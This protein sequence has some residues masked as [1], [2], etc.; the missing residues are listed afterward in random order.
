[1]VRS[2][3]NEGL[4]KHKQCRGKRHL[5]GSV[6]EVSKGGSVP[7]LKVIN[8]ADVPVLLLDGEEL[9]G[10]KQNRVLNTSILV[11]EKS[12]TI[13]P[14]SCTEQGRW[15]YTSRNFE[16][17]A[18]VMPSKMRRNKAMAV[19]G[20]LERDQ[21]FRSDQGE[22]W[23][24]VDTIACA[25]HVPCPTGAMSDVFKA[26]SND[27]DSYGDTFKRTGKQ[28]GLLVFIN[29]KIVG[30]DLLSRESAYHDLHSR[31]VRSYTIDALTR[32]QKGRGSMK[33][34]PDLALA[35]MKEAAGCNAQH[36]PSAGLGWDHRFSGSAVVG[37][38][39]SYQ[40]SVV[41]AAFFR[42]E[43]HER[44]ESH[45]TGY[46]SSSQSRRGFRVG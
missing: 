8:R 42:T 37:S 14:V 3:D 19:A 46:V 29:G 33:A 26:K 1:M 39:L 43:S 28:K 18:V 10:A 24:A 22:V 44:A 12:E 25:L 38:A 21:E 20:S 40:E 13:I 31:L 15:S 11:R 9:K 27:L 16:D 23:G 4:R 45:E 35:F 41:H 34:D 5:V 7:N 6:T 30:F 36:Y 32:K 17:S 2:L